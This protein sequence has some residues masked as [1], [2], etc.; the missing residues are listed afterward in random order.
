MGVEARGYAYPYDVDGLARNTAR[1]Q[2]SP[3]LLARFGAWGVMTAAKRMPAPQTLEQLCE[4]AG[5]ETLPEICAH[6]GITVK[7]E[8]KHRE[9]GEEWQHFLWSVELCFQ[10][11]SLK[12]P[13]KCGTAHH[14]KL[15]SGAACQLH[16]RDH[17][18]H[19]TPTPP[20]V[21]TVVNS[22]CSSLSATE[23][24]FS[25]WCSD[26][27]YDNDSIKALETYRACQ[28]EAIAV[29]RLFG[30]DLAD[31]IAQVSY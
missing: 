5:A 3:G 17:W 6:L 20:D 12:T 8:F 15:P 27:G 23:Q 16:L 26:Y 31:L 30:R 22:L 11:R 28:Q 14:K 13:F 2:S 9:T 19:A 21:A 7:T 18:L 10:G 25:E 4:A 29:R 1:A 24:A